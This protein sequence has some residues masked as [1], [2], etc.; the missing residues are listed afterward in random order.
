MFVQPLFFKKRS[1]SNQ[2]KIA[3]KKPLRLERFF[4]L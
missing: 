2:N 4:F 1:S 3:T